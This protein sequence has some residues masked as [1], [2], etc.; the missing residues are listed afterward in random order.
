MVWS[1]KV[2][3]RVVHYAVFR[4][5]GRAI[6]ERVDGDARAAEKLERQRKREVALGTYRGPEEVTREISLDAYADRWL[7]RRTTKTADDDRQRYRDHIAP[8]LGKRALS[9]LRPKDVADLIAELRA[10]GLAARTIR[11]VHSVLVSLLKSATF[12]EVVERNVAAGL[13]RGILP[14]PGQRT[15]PPGARGDFV[16]LV[17]AAGKIDADRR[18]LYA[19]LHLAGLRLG[20]GCGR[21]VRDL[22]TSARPLWMLH[23]HDQYD[24][25]PL[26]TARDEQTQERFVPVHPE[27]RYILDVWLTEGWPM[28]YRRDP[29]PDDFIVPDRTTLGSRTKN[30]ALKA[31]YRDCAAIGLERR[32]THAGRRWFI[33]YARADG[34]RVDLL[35]RV[36]HNAAGA[37][38]DRYT[39]FG[40]P[41]LCAEVAKLR[42]R[43]G[44]HVNDHAIAETPI[45]TV[46]APGVES[47]RRRGRPRK[48]PENGGAVAE[49]VDL[50]FP[51]VSAATM[52]TITRVITEHD[53][54]DSPRLWRAMADLVERVGRLERRHEPAREPAAHELERD[55]AVRD[56]RGR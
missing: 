23:V 49:V 19:L 33:T 27:L 48:T 13:P 4:W 7:A 56:R 20:E 32:G 41:E 15:T 37:M 11:N 36:T 28:I 21:R 2:G 46:E 34:A 44:D 38:I 3:R 14:A 17:S 1:R 30:Q 42:A 6:R 55:A 45:F 47:V 50:R 43:D 51:A 25:L 31:L 12:E 22:D 16:R 52:Q 39:Y 53:L 24:G 54:E 26:K 29:G 8:R 35:E 18:V 10:E 5:Q 9:D 40:W